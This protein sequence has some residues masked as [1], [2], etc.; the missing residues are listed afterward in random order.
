MV[1]RRLTRENTLKKNIPNKPGL[2]KMYDSNGK[3]IYVG[4][5]SKLRHRVQSYRQDDCFTAHPTKQPLRA[6]ARYFSYA[7]MPEKEARKIEKQVKKKSVYNY[8]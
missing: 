6:R 8:R 4:H 1:L 2:Y 7:V 5:A 3:M